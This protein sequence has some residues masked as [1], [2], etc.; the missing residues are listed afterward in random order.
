MRMLRGLL[1]LIPRGVVC[2]VMGREVL[3]PAG[4]CRELWSH[5]LE[6]GVT[7]SDGA[8]EVSRNGVVRGNGDDNGTDREVASHLHLFPLAWLCFLECCTKIVVGVSEFEVYGCVLA[9]IVNGDEVATSE[10]YHVGVVCAAGKVDIVL[11]C[12]LMAEDITK[13]AMKSLIGHVVVYEPFVKEL[14]ITA[15]YDS[16]IVGG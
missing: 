3:S 11:G 7:D 13:R 9:N 15:E 1:F 2:F 4:N 12:V 14:A 8:E 6:E 16:G 10:A 5:I